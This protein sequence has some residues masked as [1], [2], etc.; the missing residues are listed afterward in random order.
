MKVISKKVVDKWWTGLNNEEFQ[1]TFRMSKATLINLQA[2]IDHLEEVNC[3]RV[4]K[5]LLASVWYL[6][7]TKSFK[8]V[9]EMFD[10][11]DANC[12]LQGYFSKIIKLGSP[13]IVWPDENELKLIE[14]DF[15]MQYSFPK[16]VGVIGSLH[17]EV[18]PEGGLNQLDYYNNIMQK[19][20]IV[21][22]VVCDSNLLLRDVCVGC[23]G[24][25]SIKEIFECSPL[26][27]LLTDP[28]SAIVKNNLL[29]LGGTEHPQLHNLLTPFKFSGIDNVNE[30]HLQFNLLHNNV[31]EVVEKTFT[32][33][34]TRFPR[35][36]NVD[37]LDSELASSIVSCI[38]V[39]H[40]F[41]R[42]RNDYCELYC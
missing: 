19:Y 18:N 12:C 41:T 40:N 20:T 38:C 27:N 39:L 5:L 15:L 32:C 2:E 29:L 25:K 1:K 21:L 22:Q 24:G 14:K 16:L 31:M 23:P 11:T 37:K 7:N 13:Y 3:D 9:E 42:V 10:I 30:K 26:C 36:T 8:E 35:L 33:L 34:E 28:N 6:G 4:E 17:V